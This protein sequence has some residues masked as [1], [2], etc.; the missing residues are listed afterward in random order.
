MKWKL[1]VGDFFST[2][3]AAEAQLESFKIAEKQGVF[4]IFLIINM[5]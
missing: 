3:P 1:C 2:D 5:F 4:V